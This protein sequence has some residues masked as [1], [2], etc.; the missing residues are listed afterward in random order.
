M[1]SGLY[2]G[3]SAQVALDRRMST[4]ADNVANANTVGFRSTE[5]K[6]DEVISD[7]KAAKV[8][9]VSEGEE[10][11]NTNNGGL[12]QT[13]NSLDFAIKGDAWFALET[14][15]GQ[16][17]TRDGR[18][19]LTE[20]GDL[21][22]IRG[23]PVLD[24]GGGPIQIDAANGALTLS[25]DGAITQN[26]R[27]VAQLGIFEADMSKG[28]VRHDNSG[29]IPF[30]APEPVVDRFDAGVVQGYVEESNVNAIQEM[31]QLIT[32]TRAFDSIASLMREGEA[33]YTDAIKTLGGSK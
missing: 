11:I 33:T 5:I 19:T 6:F 8:A 1:Q 26:G 16:V 27:P 32:V 13:G 15:Q 30:S 29:V 4:L 24:A 12:N 10:Y 14:P 9:F 18:F 3:I 23:Y 7:T 31:T 21:I 28:F 2:V 22:S 17:L 25:S 20:G